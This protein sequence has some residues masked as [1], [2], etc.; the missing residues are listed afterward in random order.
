MVVIQG[1]YEK[2]IRYYESSTNGNYFEF[3]FPYVGHNEIFR[4]LDR[5]LWESK[6][7]LRF[8]NAYAGNV[9]IELSGWNNRSEN[10]FNEYFEAFMYFLRSKADTLRVTFFL[11]GKCSKDLYEHLKNHYEVQLVEPDKGE[12]ALSEVHH[13]HIG[14]GARED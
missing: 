9:L 11:E 2:I 6:H 5:F 13:V 10:D 1:T 14:F 12:V 3:T 8:Q 4:E 7:I